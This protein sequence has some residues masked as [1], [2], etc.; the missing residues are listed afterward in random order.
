MCLDIFLSIR[1]AHVRC[2]RCLCK[3]QFENKSGTFP[4]A[5]AFG[6]SAA[7]MQFGEM[8]HDGEPQPKAVMTPG[9]GAVL[10]PK[11][12]EYIR[13][14]FLRYADA[15]IRNDNSN[16]FSAPL[17]SHVNMTPGRGEFYGVD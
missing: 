8:S 11:S 4:E 2:I 3:R 10:L 15:R 17:V 14:K 9:A 1:S 16:G 7:A 12:V 5:F 13:K 6:K